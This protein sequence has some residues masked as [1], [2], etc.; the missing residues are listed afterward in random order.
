MKPLIAITM[1]DFNGIGPEVALKSL[2]RTD[3]SVSTPLWIGLPSV[4]EWTLNR[5]GLEA[6]VHIATGITDIREEMINLLPVEDTEPAEIRCGEISAIAGRYAMRSVEVAAGLCM[7][8]VTAAMVTSPISKEAISMANYAVP[9][10]TEF[11]AKLT[12]TGSYLMILTSS[13][14]TV[15]LSTIHIP[16]RDVSGQIQSDKLIR[17]LTLFRNSLRFDFGIST[18][19]VAVLGLN[20]H[21][22]DGGVLGSEEI[23]QIIPA[24]AHLN[25]EETLFHGPWSADGFFASGS[26]TSYDGVFAM[27]HDQ[28]LIPFK[29]LSF[30]GGVNF[31]AGLPIIRT[32]PDHGTAF[33]I[34]GESKADPSS[35][36]EAYNLA[37]KMV[38]NRT[39]CSVT[40]PRI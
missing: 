3:M 40:D 22:G 26:H 17:D 15:A 27:Y 37:C 5:F 9:G 29:T 36:L 12:G 6:E 38:H 23:E 14:L 19:S 30:G 39:I 34:A 11:L 2:L 25:Q 8:G 35:F 21:A 33:G 31:T 20:P 32:S 28:G 1:G 7:D 4:F 24:L 18:P 13:Q 10:H 16:L